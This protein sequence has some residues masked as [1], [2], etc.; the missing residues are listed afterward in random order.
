MCTKNIC[1]NKIIYNVISVSNFLY[2][3]CNKLCFLY[4]C[5]IK[6][7]SLRILFEVGPPMYLG[8]L[9]HMFLYFVI[10]ETEI[11]KRSGARVRN[12]A[13][14]SYGALDSGISEL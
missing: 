5:E 4:R 1:F 6:D 11:I 14:G 10:I 7:L 9:I 13:V 12:H 2:K 8:F 3:G